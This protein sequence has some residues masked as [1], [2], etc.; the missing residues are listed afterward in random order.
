MVPWCQ[1]NLRI[2]Y[3]YITLV[4]SDLDPKRHSWTVISGKWDPVPSNLTSLTF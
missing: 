3:C 2:S 4:S 1:R